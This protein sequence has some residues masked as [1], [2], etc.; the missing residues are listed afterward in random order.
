MSEQPYRLDYA[1]SADGLQWRREDD[2]LRFENPP[3]AD[4]WDAAMQAY[5]CIVPHRS[6]LFGF[7]NGNGFGQTGF[8]FA[9]VV[10]SA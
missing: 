7:Y 9:R 4:D 8:G 10:M 2:R 1:Q 3:Q 6:Q 5:P